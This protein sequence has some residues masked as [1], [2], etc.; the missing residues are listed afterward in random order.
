ML[1][2]DLQRSFI[3]LKDVDTLYPTPDWLDF[4]FNQWATLKD[5]KKVSDFPLFFKVV[6]K[7]V[8]LTFLRLEMLYFD[9]ITKNLG[10]TIYN[11][12]IFFLTL[13]NLQN[14]IIPAILILS[15]LSTW[16]SGIN[17]IIVFGTRRFRKLALQLVGTQYAID[18]LGN[19]S[20]GFTQFMRLI[21][22]LLAVFFIHESTKYLDGF[23]NQLDGKTLVEIAKKYDPNST[24][25]GDAMDGALYW[26]S[27]PPRG[28]FERISTDENFN[29]LV[30]WLTGAT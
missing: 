6:F 27:K 9:F 30:F 7:T 18:R 23:L 22:P 29:K 13:T 12:V 17:L 14:S 24:E 19:R 20:P 21:L 4:Y 25:F 26:L 11:L 1:P 3:P 28:V 2:I 16:G 10:L 5:I 8:G 15:V